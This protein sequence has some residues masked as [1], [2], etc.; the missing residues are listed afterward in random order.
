[1]VPLAAV[2]YFA[3]YVRY[4]VPTMVPYLVVCLALHR[5]LLRRMPHFVAPFYYSVLDKSFVVWHIS[6]YIGT[7]IGIKEGSCQVG[8]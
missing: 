2:I 6:A 1:M 7:K 8:N 3:D 5:H 4:V